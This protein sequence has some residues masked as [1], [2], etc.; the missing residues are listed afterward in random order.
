[1]SAFCG[2][3]GAPSNGSN[4]FCVNCGATLDPPASAPVQTGPI[5]TGPAQTGHVGLQ[6]APATSRGARTGLIVGAAVLAVLVIAGGAFAASFLL[7][8]GSSP[9][10]ARTGAAQ[11][12]R[13]QAVTDSPTEVWS[14]SADE[15]GDGTGLYADG[16]L[17]LVS[18]SGG[19]GVVRLD[20]DGQEEWAFPDGVGIQ[21]IS[22]ADDRVWVG[23]YWE[24]TGFAVLDATTGEELWRND[25]WMIDQLLDDGR[26]WARSYDEDSEEYEGAVF[27]QDG[28]VLWESEGDSLAVLG[29]TVLVLDGTDLAGLDLD[30]GEERWSVDTSVEVDPDYGTGSLAVNDGIVA[31]SGLS[32][33]AAFDPGTGEELWR[34][35]DLYEYSSVSAAGNELVYVVDSGD[36]EEYV[37][38]EALFFNRDGIVER[39]R[40]SPEDYGFYPTTVVI[41]DQHY[42]AHSDSGILYDQ[43]L[44]PVSSFK[45]TIVAAGAG[46]YQ[47]Y[48][49]E[50]SYHLLDG[51]EKW[52]RQVTDPDGYAEVLPLD[53][54]FLV[55]ESNTV[56]AFE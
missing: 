11:Q 34:E 51:D 27:D 8:D 3:C 4:R 9:S 2:A 16:D 37:D 20:A 33:V 35:G 55:T 39:V 36:S 40:V 45:G 31:V 41:E 46:F 23:T 22:A 26:A 53:G 15:E 48:R 30:T 28:E 29:D 1:M 12:Q 43:E 5:Q 54:R 56:T 17:V 32:E 18:N 13:V 52:A 19:K 25:D 24:D 50:L 21:A 49:G 44:K 7:R 6:D 38:G 14:W 47:T 42:L 10:G